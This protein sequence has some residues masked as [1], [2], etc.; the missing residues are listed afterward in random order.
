MI[1]EKLL[2]DA[3]TL[4]FDSDSRSSMMCSVWRNNSYSSHTGLPHYYY[5]LCR[6]LLYYIWSI[7]C[8]GADDIMQCCTAFNVRFD[9]LD[10]DTPD[11]K[12]YSD[13]GVTLLCDTTCHLIDFLF[14]IDTSI[15][16]Y[17][18]SRVSFIKKMTPTGF[19]VLKVPA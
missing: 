2:N 18:V 8:T 4:S 1:S 14:D 3:S 11:C 10:T 12:N 6:L 13:N 7:Q 15:S 9:V 17:S 5:L 19:L 16:T